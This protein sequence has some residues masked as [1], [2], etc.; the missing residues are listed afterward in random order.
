MPGGGTDEAG[1]VYVTSCECDY[2]RDYD[3]ASQSNGALWRIVQSDQV[4]NGV[5]APLEPEGSPA[6]SGSA[7]AASPAPSA[8]AA[9]SETPA[10]TASPE[11]SGTPAATDTPEPSGTPA[12]TDTPEPSHTPAATD[13]ASPAASA[14]ADTIT[15]VDV[16]YRPKRL[17]IAADTDVT[18]SLPNTG[19]SV[20]TFVIDELGIDVEVAPGDTGS[21]TINA[22]AGKYTFYCN[23]PG[24]RQAGME[25]TLTVK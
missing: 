22:P 14:A 4:G 16:A 23:V 15:M 6:P 11:P 9:P 5:T 19:A 7:A 21:V 13:S 1:N 10:P 24:H 17:T 12:D 8:S 3:P 2:G 25:G 20:H 18:I